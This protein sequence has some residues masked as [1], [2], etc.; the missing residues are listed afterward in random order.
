M[1]EVGWYEG[2]GGRCL[3]RRF[4]STLWLCGN[5][6]VWVNTRVGS[7]ERCDVACGEDE[8]QLVRESFLF[9]SYTGVPAKAAQLFPLHRLALEGTSTSPSSHGSPTTNRSSTAS[10]AGGRDGST[11]SAMNTSWSSNEGLRLRHRNWATRRTC[12]RSPRASKLSWAAYARTTKEAIRQNRG[13]LAERLGFL[14]RVVHGSNPRIWL[15][16]LKAYL[17]EAAD[18]S[19]AASD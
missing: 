6:V 11:S 16:N 3:W 19:H 5:W 1:P 9:S 14:G 7:L 8:R 13:N 10:S 17:G 12:F 4:N 2:P 18:Y 15:R